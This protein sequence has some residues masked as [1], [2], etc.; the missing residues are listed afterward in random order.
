MEY[1]EKGYN[2]NKNAITA[3]NYAYKM[4]DRDRSKFKEILE[5]SLRLDPDKPHSLYEL[6]RLLKR[7]NNP[8]GQKMIE[9]A[10][11][12]WKKKFDANQMS[13]SDYGWLS[14]AADELRMRDF[15]QQVR[16]SIPQFEDDK[17][18]N[19]ENLTVTSR[20]EGLIN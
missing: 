16:D 1:Y 17:I 5:E 4:K 10:F 11:D 3:F 14:S 18:Y 2:E 9:K 7:E 12:T 6:G 13:E 8:E 19:S 20:E 15:A